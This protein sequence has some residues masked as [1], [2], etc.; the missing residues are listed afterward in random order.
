MKFFF[1]I[2]SLLLTI[3][4]FAQ[5]LIPNADFEKYI[6][7][8]VLY[9]IQPG[10]PHYHFEPQFHKSHLNHINGICVWNGMPSEYLN[11]K[12][13]EKLVKN[14]K[15][16]FAVYVS[17]YMNI[18][19]F[20]GEV[21]NTNCNQYLDYEVSCYFSNE[22]ISTKYRT[23][24]FNTPQINFRIEDNN[25]TFKWRLL[26][27]EYIASGGEEYLTIGYFFNEE[28]EA[29]KLQYS[30]LIVDSIK[31]EYENYKLAKKNLSK[32]KTQEIEQTSSEIKEQYG[33]YSFDGLYKIKR[34]K[35]YN[36]YNKKL[37]AKYNAVTDTVR[38]I[39]KKYDSEE[40]KLDYNY[41]ARIEYLNNQNPYPYCQTRFYFDNLSLI[42]EMKLIT[43]DDTNFEVGKAIA[44]KNIFF[45]IDKSNLLENSTIELNRLYNFLI[46]NPGIKIEI[47]G[48]TDNTG[49]EEHNIELSEARAKSVT[50]YL[51]NLEIERDRL[52][53]KGYGS[54]KPLVENSS[55]ENRQINRRVEFKILK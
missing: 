2:F 28:K 23:Q 22:P 26:E 44:L 6:E 34:K 46:Q 20:Y 24:L 8:S 9:W 39:L 27:S 32:R 21:N 50:D 12:L 54:S 40:E 41:D 53:Y 36:E 37:M 51:I 43:F 16:Y 17:Q 19:N 5:N 11:I 31:F 33:G 1:L 13:K 45:D 25:N 30:E 18:E 42:P 15:Y 55:N 4:L 7:D 52:L 49:S 48:H 38:K 3:N 47:S 10:P 35:E 29:Q 14:Q